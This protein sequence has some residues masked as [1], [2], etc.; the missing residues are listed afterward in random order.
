MSKIVYLIASHNNP[1][2]LLRLV[3]TIKTES[4]DAQVLIHHD[5]SS[6]YLD[7]STFKQLNDVHILEN[8]VSVK[9]GEFSM[10][11][12]E[13]RC[14]D[15]LIDNSIEFDWL[16]F[17]S[18]QDYPIKPLA[19]IEEFLN[20]TEYDGFVEYY[21]AKPSQKIQTNPRAKFWRR[22]FY[23]YYKISSAPN[24]KVAHAIG[25]II[26]K[27]QPFVNLQTH[28]SGVYLGIRS[29]LTPFDS[30]FLA[31]TGSQWHTLSYRCIRYIHDFVDANPA[32]VKYYQKT[33]I[34]DEYFFQTI[35]INNPQIN[36][37]ND[38]KRY[39]AW[40]K[41]CPT[42]LSDQDFDGLIASNQHFARKFDSNVDIQILERLDQYFLANNEKVTAGEPELQK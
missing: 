32:F 24:L 13:L 16:I 21:L 4:P 18:G 17:L 39:I 38:N 6:C 7:S 30:K 12:M 26:N 10:V 22:C 35:L 41:N 1:S 15:W 3:K 28:K 31:Y 8:Y 19:E 40:D 20:K 42:I 23:Q 9:W 5:Y 33:L 11:Q 34:P 14:I 25:R 36:I 37:F 27:R 2:Q 29:F